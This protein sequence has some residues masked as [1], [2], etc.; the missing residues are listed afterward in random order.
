MGEMKR[1]NSRRVISGRFFSVL[2]L[3]AGLCILTGLLPG[4]EGEREKGD[5]RAGNDRV[6]LSGPPEGQKVLMIAEQYGLAYAPLQ[7]L[8]RRGFLREELPE[9][10]IEWSRLGNTATIRE[11]MLAGRLDA[12]FMGIPPFLIG[13]DR[14][15]EW[16]IFTGLSRAPLGLVT[17]REDLRELGDFGPEDRIALPQPG[18]IQHILLSMAC[19]REL[20]DAGALDD[21]LVTMNHPDGMQSLLGRSSISAHFTS[22]PYLME[23]L[24]VPGMRLVLSG[25]EA[26]GGEFTFIAGTVTNRLIKQSPEVVSAVRRA[27]EKAF[28]FIEKEPQETAAI[29][30]EEYDMAPEKVEEYLAW[31]GLEF[32]GEILGI[33]EF[34]TFMKNEGYLRGDFAATELVYLKP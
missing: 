11:A 33:E 6:E 25:E 20:G 5:V 22:P 19:A 23:E 16:K 4:C 15:M 31:E 10:T 34:V 12:G 14:G 29:L 1:E 26:M 28:D 24:S 30:A 7:I 2:A 18:S 8:R 32:G 9:Y 17:W 21:L 3:C 13:R 27:L